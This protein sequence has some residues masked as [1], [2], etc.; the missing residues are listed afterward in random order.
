MNA[1]IFNEY[2]HTII[3]PFHKNK[4]LLYYVL[5]LLQKNVLTIFYYKKDIFFI[6]FEIL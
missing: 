2:K 6:D 3:I 5:N 1:M 4:K